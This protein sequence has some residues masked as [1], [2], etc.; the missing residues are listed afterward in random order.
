M[1]GKR[2]SDESPSTAREQPGIAGCGLDVEGL[3]GQRERYH[4]LAEQVAEIRREPEILTIKFRPDFDRDLLE[5]TI[6][7]ESECCPFFTFSYPDGDEVLTIKVT[8]HE[9]RESLDALAYSFGGTGR[10]VL[11]TR[12]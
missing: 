10:K 12:S 1:V 8:G 3:R 9:Y 7:V 4:R 5:K 11:R 6:A 2:S